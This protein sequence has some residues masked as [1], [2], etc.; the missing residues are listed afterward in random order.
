[1]KFF[2]QVTIKKSDLSLCLTLHII[3]ATESIKH[4]QYV[5]LSISL[6]GFFQ[7]L[8]SCFSFGLLSLCISQTSSSFRQHFKFIC[9]STDKQSYEFALKDGSNG[10]SD[11]AI[12]KQ[13]LKLNESMLSQAF[14]TT[15]KPVFS[16]LL[17]YVS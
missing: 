8:L 15:A 5:K 11:S 9:N 13:S 16:K 7:L 6:P 2:S 14:C 4:S 17:Q 1:M 12:R 10:K 3:K